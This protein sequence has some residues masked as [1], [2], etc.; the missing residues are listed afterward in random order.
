MKRQR[1]KR[2][3]Q[4]AGLSPTARDKGTLPRLP[5][6]TADT[7]VRPAEEARLLKRV[8]WPSHEPLAFLRRRGGLA[9]GHEDDYER[10]HTAENVEILAKLLG[11]G[12][13]H[14]IHFYKGMGLKH[15]AEEMERGFALAR[16]M[17]RRGEVSTAGQ[18]MLLGADFFLTGT[19]SS[20]D[21]MMNGKRSTFTSYSFRLTDAESSAII[22]EDEYDV[23]KVGKSGMYDR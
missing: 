5:A 15:E 12:G 2:E 16:E 7:I 11:P 19:L 20:I 10:Y 9:R 6:T 14:I 18:K 1:G 3:T 4:A 22:W 21:K 8:V 17:K 13:T 23:K